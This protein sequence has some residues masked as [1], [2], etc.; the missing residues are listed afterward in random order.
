MK[1]ITATAVIVALL[2]QSPS[3]PD[4]AVVTVLRQSQPYVTATRIWRRQSITPTLDVVAVLGGSDRVAIRE[5]SEIMPG[6]GPLGLFLQEREPPYRVFTLSITTVC[7]YGD[8]M[9]VSATDILVACNDE[10]SDVVPSDKFVYD[11]RAKQLVTR[12]SYQPFMA[13]V[14]ARRDGDSAVLTFGNG[15]RTATVAFRPGQQPPLHLIAVRRATAESAP[16]YRGQFGDTDSRE[17]IR[18]GPAERFATEPLAAGGSYEIEWVVRD[19]A[20]GRRYRLPR[21]TLATFAKAR[22]QHARDRLNGGVAEFEDRIGPRATDGDRLWFGKTFYD[23]EGVEGVGGLGYFDATTSRFEILTSPLIA[24]WSAT[25]IHVETDHVWLALATRGEYGDRSG[26]VLRFDR[27]D[28]RFQ[29][30]ADTRGIGGQFLRV[31]GELLLVTDVGVTTI[32]AAVRHYLVDQ[33]SDGR[34]RIIEVER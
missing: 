34:L 31:G 17:V 8:L 13:T 26:G 4:R 18:F 25:A 24:D 2:N 33:T 6:L 10:K 30:V 7:G 21:S 1:L 3:D 23:G 12:F 27:R 22:P 32:G 28:A 15:E 20:N 14:R 5:P 9:R 19:T 16:G 29:K 11:P